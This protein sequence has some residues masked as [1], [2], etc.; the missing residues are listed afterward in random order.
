MML[1]SRMRGNKLRSA[2]EIIP[3]VYQL[4]IGAS[5]VIVVNEEELTVIDTGLPGSSPR[6]I[7]FLR[8]LGRSPEEI[9]LIIVTHN[10]F[11]HV[12]GLVELRR[13]TRAKV[14]AHKADVDGTEGCLP[15]PGMVRRLLSVRPFSNLRPV[16]LLE[17]DLVDIQLAGG[18]V[19]EPL[20]G[21]EVIHTP[22]HTPGSISLFSA[23]KRLLIVG[24]ALNKRRQTLRLPPKMVSANQ[25][26]A[27]NSIRR[28]AQLD[29]D[30]L[31]LGHGRPLTNDTHNKMMDLLN[32]IKD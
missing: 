16:F 27:M 1:L 6:I 24:D 32:K 23:Q 17:P 14:A 13:L 2:L 22:G 15:Y 11:D 25:A 29:F 5:N 9:N 7:E 3:N 26:Q 20:G 30:I 12:G 28:M 4:N 21:L 18:E 19:L 10:H 8:S 31:C